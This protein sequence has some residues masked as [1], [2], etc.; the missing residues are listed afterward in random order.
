MTDRFNLQRFVDAQSQTYALAVAEL[1]AGR[2][3]SHWMWF[4]FPQIEG[5]GHSDMARRYAL[6]GLAEARAYLEH[7]VLG[8]RLRACGRL[9]ADIDGRPIEAIFGAPDDLKFHSCMTLFAQVPPFDPV[10]NEC[11]AK[12]FLARP[13][14]S[15]LAI[16][17][18]L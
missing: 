17:A 16:L 8:V 4:V 1:G 12:Y 14:L 9:V 7:P 11:L 5:L 10:F 15:T 2:K 3:R 18:R 6:S 13:D